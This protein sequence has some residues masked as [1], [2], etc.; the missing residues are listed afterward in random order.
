MVMRTEAA[1]D[2]S[3]A[4]GAAGLLKTEWS[5]LGTLGRTA[6]IALVLSAAI[7]VALGVTIPHQV[8]HFLLA[9][10]AESLGTVVDGFVIDQLIPT[11][12]LSPS[13][14]DDLD[15]AVQRRLMGRE[16]VRVKLW[17]ADGTIVYSDAHS[18]IG[19]SYSP[20]E[21]LVK[22][23]DGDTRYGPPDLMRP[24][25]AADRT[26]GALIEFYLPV[27]AA[28]GSI[29]AV[30]EVYENADPLFATVGSIRTNVWAS[31]TIGI[32][33]LAVFTIV[34]FVRNGRALTRRR[35]QA[36]HLLSELVNAQEEER[37]RVVGALHDDIG[38]PLYRIHFGIE[39]CR[40]RVEPGTAVDDELARI[41]TLVL[42]V[43]ARLRTE[44]RRLRDEPGAELDL[45][46]AVTDLA[47]TTGRETDLVVDVGLDDCRG[48]SLWQRVNL[49]RAAQEGITNVRKHAEA[50]T[51]SIRLRRDGETVVLDVEDDGV[52]ISSSPGLG[53]VTTK[54]RLAT[55]GGGLEVRKLHTSGTLFRAWVPAVV[56]EGGEQ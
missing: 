4:A 3:P 53:L 20:S 39:D 1:T 18:L 13:E 44:L 27:E 26:Y 51:I 6:V 32:G 7:A 5:V 42:G 29:G 52:G 54:E 56:D 9:S 24:E 46:D 25:N 50:S 11:G 33:F 35:R 16:A 37:K 28:D 21:D 14:L 10:E 43:E 55:L 17:T 19:R 12:R 45:A 38:Q 23:F 22:A 49:F 8:E 36:E 2:T 15:A 40:A 48:L 47:E 41:G 30:F 31:I 34:L